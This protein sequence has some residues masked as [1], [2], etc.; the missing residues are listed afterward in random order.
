VEGNE[1]E[2]VDKRVIEERR[3]TQAHFQLVARSHPEMVERTLD[4]LH[5]FGPA[6]NE[7]D[8]ALQ[9]AAKAWLHEAGWWGDSDDDRIEIVRKLTGIN[10]PQRSLW[11]KLF[12][13]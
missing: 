7:R 1:Q 8:F 11:R 12:R 4:I 3:R 2:F 9:N 5:F 6:Q 13:R 10:M